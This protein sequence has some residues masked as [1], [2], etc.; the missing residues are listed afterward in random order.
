MH[1]VVAGA[2]VLRDEG[3]AYAVMY[4]NTG[5]DVQL[6]IIPGAPHGLTAATEAWSS[7][8]YWTN[9][10]RVLNVALNTVF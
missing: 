2:D 6:E 1:V 5:S 4:R 7:R 10:V 8:Q 9:Q 3:I